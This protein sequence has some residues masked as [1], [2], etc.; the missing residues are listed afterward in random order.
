M[1]NIASCVTVLR[2][3]SIVISAVLDLRVAAV[4][5]KISVRFAS[6]FAI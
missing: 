4:V 2:S 5:L 3:S 1:E 6:G